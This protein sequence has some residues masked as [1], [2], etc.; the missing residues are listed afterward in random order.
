MSDLLAGLMPPFVQAVE[1]FADT[2]DVVLF[3]EEEAHIANAVDKRRREFTTARV[4]ARTAL[5]RLGVAP[6]PILPGLRGAPSWP[7]GVVGSMTH[8]EGY[9]AGAV[10]RRT[11]VLT[12]GIDAEPAAQLPDGVLAAVAL[13]AELAMI[14]RLNA[15]APGIPW[16]RLLFSAKEAVYKSWF[17][18]T[19]AW[20]DFSEARIELDPTAQTFTASLLVPGPTIGGRPLTGFS[21]RW[22]N[23]D[24]LVLTTIVVPAP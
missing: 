8:C 13:P 22:L 15:A 21:G 11:D 24:G 19:L 23:R 1:A 20:L 18:L 6:A 16:D 2:T 4:C 9:R 5:A 12:I 10:A 17:P 7:G 14:S 3:P